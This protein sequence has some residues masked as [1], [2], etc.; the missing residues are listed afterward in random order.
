MPSLPLAF[1][2]LIIQ[3]IVVLKQAQSRSTISGPVRKLPQ[4]LSSREHEQVNNERHR[5]RVV[6]S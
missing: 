5:R 3:N 4:V 2:P 6:K 1:W